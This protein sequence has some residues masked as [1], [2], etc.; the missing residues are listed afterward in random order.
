MDDMDRDQNVGDERD[1]GVLRSTTRMHSRALHM[2]LGCVQMLLYE[3][4]YRAFRRGELA[5]PHQQRH[6]KGLIDRSPILGVVP[7]EERQSGT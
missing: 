2:P 1:G 4:E 6:R 5:H 3:L 7:R